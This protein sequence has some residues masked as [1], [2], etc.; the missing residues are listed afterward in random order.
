MLNAYMA[1]DAAIRRENLARLL[2]ARGLTIH[3]MVSQYGRTYSYWRDLLR[4][5]KK[6]FGEKAARSIEDEAQLPRNWLDI[7]LAPVPS[8]AAAPSPPGYLAPRWLFSYELFKALHVCEADELQ[9]I[10]NVIRAVVGLPPTD[11]EDS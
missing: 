4:D 8:H 7:P 3:D 10:E 6:S 1:D 9:R 2:A 11:R 5:P